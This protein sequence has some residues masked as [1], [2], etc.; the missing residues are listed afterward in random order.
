MIET[1]WVVLFRYV[2]AMFPQQRFDEYTPEAWYDVLGQ[3]GAAETRAAIAAC[4]AAKP[5]V[6]PAEIVAAIRQH[7]ADVDRDLHGAGQYA[8]IPDAD[9]D[10]VPAYLAALRTQRIRAA[11]GEPLTYRPRLAI[12]AAGVGRKVPT[13]EPVRRSG[14]RSIRCPQCSAEPGKSCRTT[15]LGRRMADVH[16]S[17]LDAAKRAA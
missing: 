5:F 1:E 11:A 10:D 16:P 12:A 7:R 14:P 8:E 3:Y 4:A 9:P 17:R 13:E 6:S 15:V 2:R